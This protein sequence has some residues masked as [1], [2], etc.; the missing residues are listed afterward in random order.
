MSPSN[1]SPSNLLPADADAAPASISPRVALQFIVL[2][3][4]VSLFADMTYEGARSITGPYLAILGASGA[5]VGIVAGAGELL[6]YGLRLVGGYLADRT[7]RYWLLTGVGYAVNLLAVPALALTGRWE[8]AAALMILER[9]GKA[10]RAPARDAMLSHATNTV[11]RGWGFG[12]HEALDQIG[13]VTGPLL[14]AG[15]LLWDEGARGY[16][17]AFAALLIP[18]LL[19]LTTLTVAWR[20]F[21]NPRHFEPTTTLPTVDRGL[22]RVYWLYL[23]AAALVALGYADFPL[24][25]FHLERTGLVAPQTIPLF[26]AGAM[27]LDAVAALGFGRLFDTVGI[28]LLSGV[29]LL[30]AGFAPLVFLGGT[31]GAWLGMA[32]WGIGMG[33]QESI[34]RATVAELA[35]ADRR[36]TAYGLFNAG[37]GI[38]WFVGSALLGMLYDRWVPGLVLMSVAAQLAA[39]PLFWHVHRRYHAHVGSSPAHWG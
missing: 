9:T 13:A 15:V 4:I 22:P 38:A 3:G 19:A 10:I 25:A 7:G 24:I 27:A 26:Y 1:G 8:W 20:R 36:G 29:A 6:G 11:G 34:L 21:P 31:A 39:V 30:A 17:I 28:R 32:L 33:A 16:R 35:P 18:A 2:L 37:Y 14:L 5:A 12:L 23:A